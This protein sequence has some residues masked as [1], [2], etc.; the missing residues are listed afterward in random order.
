MTPEEYARAY[1]LMEHTIKVIKSH[2]GREE[3]YAALG[4]YGATNII[5]HGIEWDDL[6]REK[7]Q[8]FLAEVRHHV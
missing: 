4:A 3:V 2:I 8:W 1:E 5:V 7:M 6:A